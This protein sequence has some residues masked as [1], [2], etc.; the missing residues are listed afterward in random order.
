MPQIKSRALRE[1]GNN[2]KIGC[3]DAVLPHRKARI[4]MPGVNQE[5]GGRGC[6]GTIAP[7]RFHS[8]L[9]FRIVGMITVNAQIVKLYEGILFRVTM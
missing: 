4:P 5:F 7:P 1:K 2:T 8:C 6:N 3:T 9:I